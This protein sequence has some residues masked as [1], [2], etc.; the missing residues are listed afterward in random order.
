MAEV[1]SNIGSEE[2]K[3]ILTLPPIIWSQIRHQLHPLLELKVGIDNYLLLQWS[4]RRLRE[5]ADIRYLSSEIYESLATYF[6]GSTEKKETDE[7]LSEAPTLSRGVLLL[8]YI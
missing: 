6:M 5:I 3:P 1:N 7:T 2:S 4:H 8:L